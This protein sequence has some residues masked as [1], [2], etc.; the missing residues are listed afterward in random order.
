MPPSPANLRTLRNPFLPTEPEPWTPAWV[1]EQVRGRMGRR[2]SLA[3]GMFVAM[4]LLAIVV[5]GGSG[6]KRNVMITTTP[7]GAAVEIDGHRIPDKTTPFEL[8][9]APG[10]HSF[11]FFLDGHEERAVRRVVVAAGSKTLNPAPYVLKPLTRMLTVRSN[12]SGARIVIDGAEKSTTN[13]TVAVTPG[14]HMLELH[15]PGYQKFVKPVEVLQRK[16]TQVPAGLRA[17]PPSDGASGLPP[18]RPDRTSWSTGRT[19]R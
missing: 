1:S 11:E 8:P 18:S 6:P 4:A 2:S 15:L 10:D 13:G 7:P 14:R 17:G 3:L 5:L 16:S 9:I 19:S 12:P